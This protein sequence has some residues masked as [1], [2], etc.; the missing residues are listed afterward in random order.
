MSPVSK[1]SHKEIE[2]VSCFFLLFIF[3]LCVNLYWKS[4]SSISLIEWYSLNL[5]FEISSTL[6]PFSLV[7]NSLFDNSLNFGM[8]ILIIE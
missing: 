6:F 7:N 5:K 3:I 4:F 1:D 2:L 8:S